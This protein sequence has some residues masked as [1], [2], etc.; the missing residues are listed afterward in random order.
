MLGGNDRGVAGEQDRRGVLRH[1]QRFSR[2][3]LF[4]T[5]EAW[6]PNIKKEEFAG[7]A[8]G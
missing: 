1:L 4:T 3:G 7:G 5:S 6:P 8:I 2:A